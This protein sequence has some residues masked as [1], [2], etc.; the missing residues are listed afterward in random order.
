MRKE[1]LI[2][3][4]IISICQLQLTKNSDFRTNELDT[5]DLLDLIDKTHQDKM[6]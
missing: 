3:L 1:I 4:A 2:V 6:H 5:Q